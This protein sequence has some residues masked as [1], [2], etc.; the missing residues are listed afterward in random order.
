MTMESSLKCPD[1]DSRH[2]LAMGLTVREL[3]QHAAK[4]G[5]WLMP[6]VDRFA[7]A[8]FWWCHR[9]DNGGA[10]WL[11]PPGTGVREDG[12]SARPQAEH[13]TG[14]RARGRGAA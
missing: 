12:R 5:V 9:C 1:C 7:G 6:G 8:S 11:G 14:S 3:R 10:F 4:A 13:R 2:G